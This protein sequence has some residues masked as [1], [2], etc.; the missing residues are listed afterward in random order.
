MILL[1]SDLIRISLLTICSFLFYMTH[2]PRQH[3]GRVQ[4]VSSSIGLFFVADRDKSGTLDPQ[5]ALT[6]LMGF[7]HLWAP[8]I[9]IWYRKSYKGLKVVYSI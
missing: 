1:S 9:S 8:R 4:A 3:Q 5:E 7:S 6:F 2:E